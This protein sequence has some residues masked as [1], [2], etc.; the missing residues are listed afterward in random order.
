MAVAFIKYV[1][2]LCFGCRL[3]EFMGMCYKILH[4]L[5]L[6]YVQKCN[7]K[8]TCE[9]VLWITARFNIVFSETHHEFTIVT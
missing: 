2:W 3:A 1:I 8:C 9:D 5:F 7:G 6:A 4:M